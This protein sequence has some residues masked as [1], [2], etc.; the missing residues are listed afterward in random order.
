[1]GAAALPA[2]P[3]PFIAALGCTSGPPWRAGAR[4]GQTTGVLTGTRCVDRTGQDARLFEELD[5]CSRVAG[6]RAA[7]DREGVQV[8]PA[9][10]V[11]IRV[12]GEGVR[13]PMQGV[14]AG[15]ELP[16]RV[17]IGRSTVVP[18]AEELRVREGSGATGRGDTRAASWDVGGGRWCSAARS[19]SARCRFPGRSPWTRARTSRAYRARPRPRRSVRRSERR[20]ARLARRRSRARRCRWGQCSPDLWGWR[21]LPRARRRCS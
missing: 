9:N 2:A 5:A 3:S 12:Q 15:P 6:R 10:G 21:D 11:A 18:D 17:R 20:H 4:G 7:L 13:S 14:L 16:G 19:R 8:A 1:M